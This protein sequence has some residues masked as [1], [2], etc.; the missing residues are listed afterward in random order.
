MASKK[1]RVLQIK[2]SNLVGLA[3]WLNELS[4]EAKMSRVRTRFINELLESM[5]MTEKERQQIIGKY[6][7]K[8]KDKDGNEV[9]SKD[10]DN[11]D[12]KKGST[13]A[14]ETEL[15]ELYDESFIMNLTPET[16]ENIMTVKDILLNTKYKFGPSE[17]EHPAIKQQ[18]IAQANEYVVWCEA[19]EAV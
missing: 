18:K 9:W 17:D 3:N 19:F 7:N 12:I 11:W 6:V 10:G 8:T 15:G 5:K 2:K 16:E 4:L 13:E 14:F 1:V